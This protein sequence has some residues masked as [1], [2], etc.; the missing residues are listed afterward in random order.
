MIVHIYNSTSVLQR[1][2][3]FHMDKEEI[4]QIAIDGAR[5]VKERAKDFPGNLYL[6][7]SPESFTGTE[8]EFAL[9]IC[10][11]VQDVWQPTPENRIIFNLPATVEMNT[12]NVYADQIEWMS[13]HFKDRENIILSLHPAQRPGNRHCGYGVRAFGRRGPCGGHAVRQRGADRKTWISSTSH[14]IC[15][16][17]GLTRS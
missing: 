14:T 6:E 7:Y 3:V 16:L 9:D 4:K 11:A 2:V 5:M 10:T 15:F 17:R 8:V 1:D 12:P 13:R